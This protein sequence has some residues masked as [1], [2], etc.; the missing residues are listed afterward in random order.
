MADERCVVCGL[1]GNPRNVVTYKGK[2]YKLC[3]YRCKKRFDANAELY[4]S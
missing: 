4:V 2:Q 3:C 1:S